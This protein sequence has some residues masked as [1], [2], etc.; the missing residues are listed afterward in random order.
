MA[1][2]GDEGS[3]ATLRQEHGPQH[4]GEVLHGGGEPAGAEAP[5]QEPHDG[6]GSGP[7]AGREGG[8][9]PASP[10]WVGSQ[11]PFLA[12]TTCSLGIWT[13]RPL[14]LFVIIFMYAYHLICITFHLSHMLYP[15]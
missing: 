3:G 14:L 4:G 15:I 10:R 5:A 1:G 2:V 6:A 11:C 9:D 12:S 7:W 13:Q 8:G